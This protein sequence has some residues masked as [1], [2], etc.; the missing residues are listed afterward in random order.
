MCP[1][2]ICAS[3][4]AK[5][6]ADTSGAKEKTLSEDN[7]KA[8]ALALGQEKAQETLARRDTARAARGQALAA[9]PAKLSLSTRL[10]N[11]QGLVSE[12]SLQT[13]GY[14]LAIGDSW[15]D[16]PFY[17]VLKLLDDNYGYNIEKTAHAGDRIESMAYHGG[18]MDEFAR[19]AEKIQSH[20]ATPKAVLVSGG[21]NDLAGDEFG[22]LL[23]S[24]ASPIHGWNNE[25]VDGVINQRI[26]GAYIA[27]LAFINT[28]CLQKFGKKLP[29]LVH[30]YDYPVPDGRGFLGG[31]FFLPGPW[32][33]PGFHEKLFDNLAT[34]VA[35]M[36]DI[37]DR[38][39]IMVASLAA[40]P[41]FNN[42]HYVNL[43]N[44]LSSN[45]ANYEDSWGNELHPTENGF[46]AVT[47]KFAAQLSAL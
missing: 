16:Y 18:Q 41:N 1:W 15:F 3:L 30:G 47:N 5:I 22:M 34:N 42:V 45:P 28:V 46:K 14:L 19:S 4:F 37:I 39:N 7:F 21:G 32:L 10:M 43:R 11:V 2:P 23:N 31:W 40:D 20:G 27:L 13:A 24:A 35:L 17:D 36:Q 8:V 12:A 29:I 44:T 6:N 25:I 38:F 26:S 9:H 33:Q